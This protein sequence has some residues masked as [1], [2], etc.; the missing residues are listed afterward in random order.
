MFIELTNHKGLP[1]LIN[2]ADIATVYKESDNTVR[3]T[4]LS[5]EQGVFV[6]SYEMVKE[7]L[8]DCG[9]YKV[10]PKKPE[11]RCTIWNL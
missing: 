6:G 4:S 8:Y 3:I 10:Q 5:G 7:Y 9:C 11:G 2:I 1:Q